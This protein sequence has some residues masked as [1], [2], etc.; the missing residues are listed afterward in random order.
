MIRNQWKRSP[1]ASVICIDSGRAY[2]LSSPD[3]GS[4]SR[5]QGHAR[6]T[7][8]H[9][10]AGK[11]TSMRQLP[12]HTTILIPYPSPF[13]IKRINNLISP[14]YHCFL[15]ISILPQIYLAT[16]SSSSQ[17]RKLT[18]AAYG[19]SKIITRVAIC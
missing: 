7:P 15:I 6:A 12:Q 11:R 10:Q 9:T 14:S 17:L 5:R 1:R 8:G 19:Y 18:V 16:A 3:S 4:S 13:T 2:V